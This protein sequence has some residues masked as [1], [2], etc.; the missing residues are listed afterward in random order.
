M[1][2]ENLPPLA[3][4]GSEAGFQVTISNGGPSNVSKL[5]LGTDTPVAPDYVTTTQ[6]KC[7]APGTRLSCT[8]GA[9][10]KGRA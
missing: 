10:R 5:V 9:L 3:A 7:T 6:G 1:T 4:A 2:V 8:F